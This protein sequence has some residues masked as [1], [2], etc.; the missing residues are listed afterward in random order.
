MRYKTIDFIRGVI[1]KLPDGTYQIGDFVFDPAIVR[2]IV[3][4]GAEP[5]VERLLNNDE[6]SD[7]KLKQR[8]LA[9]YNFSHLSNYRVTAP[10]PK[11]DVQSGI[12]L[13]DRRD[14]ADEAL[15]S[16]NKI[17]RGS[18]IRISNSLQNNGYRVFTDE[19]LRYRPITL[20]GVDTKYVNW[21]EIPDGGVPNV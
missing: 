17:R 8:Y 16:I 21:N 1:E 5:V 19:N 3:R 4:H 11:H 20:F 7:F 2:T 12:F 14:L 13:D 10:F 9:K 18:N 6:L 15:R